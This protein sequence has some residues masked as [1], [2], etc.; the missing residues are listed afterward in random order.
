[1]IAYGGEDKQITVWDL[2]TSS[3]VQTISKFSNRIKALSV[4]PKE[5]M[6]SDGS[7][8]VVYPYL[9]SISSDGFLKV[10]DFNVSF[11]TP[12]KEVEVPGRLVCL[13]TAVVT[14]DLAKKKRKRNEAQE[15]VGNLPSNV[16]EIPTGGAKIGGN[17]E[18]DEEGG[19]HDGGDDG[20][21]GSDHDGGDD[22]KEGSDH[23]KNKVKILH[24]GKKPPPPP[25]SHASGTI[26]CLRHPS[27]GNCSIALAISIP[28]TPP[29]TEFYILLKHLTTNI[30]PHPRKVPDLHSF[31]T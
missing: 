17:G 31:D 10:W 4:V 12:V 8:G 2:K 3:V 9:M 23:D 11:E 7:A 30:T 29:S 15:P 14:Y 26:P 24:G 25:P 18:G 27:M 5:K 16:H 6:T 21:E 19:D 13:A 28:S 22:G 1:M 20:K